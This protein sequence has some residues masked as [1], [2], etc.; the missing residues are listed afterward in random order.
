MRKAPG[1]STE[2]MSAQAD[3]GYEGSA[4]VS[5]LTHPD[6]LL[7]SPAHHRR[8]PESF[9]RRGLCTASLTFGC[10]ADTVES[11]LMNYY[12][13]LPCYFYSLW[14]IMSVNKIYF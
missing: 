9:G 1:L 14:F 4:A 7:G 12:R 6:Y 11:F 10:P 13:L 3:A 8:R 2:M 5:L